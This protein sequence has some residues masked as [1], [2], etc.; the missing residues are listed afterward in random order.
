MSP[1][2]HSLLLQSL[3]LRSCDVAYRSP[4]SS[5]RVLR[6][7]LCQSGGRGEAAPYCP[8]FSVLHSTGARGSIVS[9]VFGF[10]QQG[11]DG[12]VVSPVLGLK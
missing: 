7:A 12:S 10:I 1:L 8:L 2:Y 3:S 11:V 6:K 4:L 9:C 5:I